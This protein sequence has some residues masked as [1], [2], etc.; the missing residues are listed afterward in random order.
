MLDKIP[1][2]ALQIDLCNIFYMSCH[3]FYIANFRK[4]Y[5]IKVFFLV[6]SMMKYNT[7]D[8]ATTFVIKFHSHIF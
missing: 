3:L 7:F 5:N 2:R 8:I 6:P 1:E 4:M